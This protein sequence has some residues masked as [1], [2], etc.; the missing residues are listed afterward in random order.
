M[1]RIRVIYQEHPGHGWSAESPDLPG[2][3]VFGD[4][5]KDAHKLAEDGVRFVLH[6]DAEERGEPTP[7]T[8]LAIEHYVPAPA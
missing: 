4:S 1:D 5:Y 8:Y 6:C 7:T 2:W 3:R